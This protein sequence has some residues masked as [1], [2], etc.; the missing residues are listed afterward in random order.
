M[1]KNKNKFT[2]RN[3]RGYNLKRTGYS[4]YD[5]KA[6]TFID[7]HRYVTLKYAENLQLNLAAT[8][9]SQYSFNLNSIFDPDRTGVGHQPYGFDQLA[10]LYNRYRVLKANWRVVFSPANTSYQ[11]LVLP[12]N[13][14]LVASITTSGTWNTAAESPRAKTWIQGASGQSKEI[15]GGISLN[16]LNGCLWV[17]YLGD[18]RFEAQVT[19][20]PIELMTLNIGLYNPGASAII[21]NYNVEIWYEVD[22][23]DPLPLGGS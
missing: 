5:S 17:E 13:G 3:A 18:D 7:P 4:A 6:I 10:A 14:T 2:Q 1:N 9:G 19:N 8:T 20:S 15:V 21:I 16:D 11:A 23:H 22:L 12:L